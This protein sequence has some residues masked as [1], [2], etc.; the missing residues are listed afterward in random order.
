M[1]KI[2]LFDTKGKTTS[3]T[4]LPKEIF[5][6]KINKPLLA[7]AVKVFLANQRQATANAKGRGATGG[8]GKKIYR[9]KGTGHARHGDKYAPTFVGGGSAHG[10]SGNQN[11]SLKLNQKMKQ[12]ALF[13]ALS[14][15]L[16]EKKVIVVKDLEKLEPKTKQIVQTLENLKIGDRKV[17]LVVTGSQP[18]LIRAARNIAKLKIVPADSLNAYVVLNGGNLVFLPESIDKLKEVYLTKK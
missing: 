18:N 16:K 6:A 10:P 15:S 13:S 12:R 14:N 3:Q 1:P 9:Q 7:Q 2:D 5:A 17:L 8:S 4:E 11:F